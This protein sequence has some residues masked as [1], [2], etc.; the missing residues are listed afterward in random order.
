[1]DR[2]LAY[3]AR[4][5]ASPWAI[6]TDMQGTL[7]SDGEPAQVCLPRLRRVRGRRLPA[8]AVANVL[9]LL[10]NDAPFFGVMPNRSPITADVRAHSSI[11][12]HVY[13]CGDK[14]VDQACDI[15]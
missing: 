5:R 3:V 10:V 14:L 6:F 2:Q 12:S 11:L 9:S 8:R 4:C 7:V 13:R 1:M 15:C